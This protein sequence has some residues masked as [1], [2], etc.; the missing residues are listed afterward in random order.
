MR[1]ACSFLFSLLFAANVVAQSHLTID[2]VDREEINASVQEIAF[3]AVLEGTIDDLNL[4]VFV[5]HP[6]I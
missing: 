3:S 2:K 4:A 6:T 1:I 5:I